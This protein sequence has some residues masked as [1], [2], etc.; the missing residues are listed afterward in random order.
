MGLRRG[1]AEL[2]VGSEAWPAEQHGLQVGEKPRF[3]LFVYV[4][5]VHASLDRIRDVAAAVLQEATTMPWGEVV[6]YVLDP[7][8]NP[9][10]LAMP[11]SAA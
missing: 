9:E 8:G 5:D 7:D 11:D 2:G 3:E 10:A 4:D 1:T 6:G